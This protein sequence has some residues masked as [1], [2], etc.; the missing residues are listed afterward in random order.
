MLR[1]EE[2]VE[3]GGYT[4]SRFVDESQPHDLEAPASAIT[5][6][7]FGKWHRIYVFLSELDDGRVIVLVRQKVGV[8]MLLE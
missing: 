8:W 4:L 7:S 6:Q 3:A 5:Y 1:G 2:A